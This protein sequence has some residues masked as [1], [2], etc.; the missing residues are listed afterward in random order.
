M[1]NRPSHSAA[2][3]AAALLLLAAAPASAVA[4]QA[5]AASPLPFHAGQWG[6]SANVSGA[7]NGLGALRFT[8]P[9]RALVL[10]LGFA[11]TRQAQTV[12]AGPFSPELSQH[13]TGGTATLS[14]GLRH[15]RPLSSAVAFFNT[16]GVDGNY[17]GGGGGSSHSWGAGVFGDLGA[18]YMLDPRFSLG[19][20]TGLHLGYGEYRYPA[21]NGN[22]ATNSTVS[23]HSTPAR[24][25]GAVYF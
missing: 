5:S 23:L 25:I 1:S 24:F 16:L 13:S 7:G 18:Q 12:P 10:D 17:Q 2:A 3:V 21:G 22:V 15:F 8:A 6:I 4:Q 9:N 11:I 20:A 19:V 14:L